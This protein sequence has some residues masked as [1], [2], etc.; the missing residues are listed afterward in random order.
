VTPGAATT[1]E[2]QRVRA[3]VARLRAGVLAVVFGLVGGSGLAFAT[4]WLVLRG[5]EVVGPHLGL[6]SQFFP[7]YSV[8][9]S[10]VAI[11]FLYGLVTGLILGAFLGAT[12]NRVA[13]W[14]RR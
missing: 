3:A 4:A 2:H 14:R 12:Y 6:L 13:D 1:G 10:G 9:W 5:G 11:G 8:S 7:G